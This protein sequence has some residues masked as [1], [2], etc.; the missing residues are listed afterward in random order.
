MEALSFQSMTIEAMT[1]VR[2]VSREE[3][4]ADGRAGSQESYSDFNVPLGRTEA[5]ALF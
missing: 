2:R 3:M 1:V 5:T 4:A